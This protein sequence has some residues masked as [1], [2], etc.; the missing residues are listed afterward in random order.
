MILGHCNR[1]SLVAV[2]VSVSLL[3]AVDARA[4][5]TADVV[6]TVTDSSGAIVPGATVTLTN[7]GTNVSQTA[8][9]AGDGNYLFTLLQ[10]GSYAIKVQ[11]LWRS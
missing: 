4:Q 3:C 2:L 6:G 11:A 8:Q 7:A 5:D 1:L 9:S 10:V